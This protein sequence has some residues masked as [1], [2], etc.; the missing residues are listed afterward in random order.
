MSRMNRLANMTGAAAL[1]LLLVCGCSYYKQVE[2]TDP[3]MDKWKAKAQE[4]LSY[5]PGPSQAS[6]SGQGPGRQAGCHQA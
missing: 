5:P 1:C 2:T 3:F 4:S 6:Q